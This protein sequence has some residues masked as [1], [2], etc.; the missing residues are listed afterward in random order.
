MARLLLLHLEI[1]KDEK[2]DVI[3]CGW[4]SCRLVIPWLSV[5]SSKDFVREEYEKEAEIGMHYVVLRSDG[6]CV[7]LS[8]RR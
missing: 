1:S 2:G 6:T 5:V 4:L 7:D 3:L 8:T